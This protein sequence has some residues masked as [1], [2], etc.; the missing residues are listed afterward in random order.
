MSLSPCLINE[1]HAIECAF[2]VSAG[3]PVLGAA[4]F[5][6]QIN[7]IRAEPHQMRSSF[8][9]GERFSVV[10]YIPHFERDAVAAPTSVSARFSLPMYPQ[11]RDRLL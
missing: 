5:S 8:G 6:M 4:R 3:R 10:V 7:E 9:F 11:R 2:F 1:L